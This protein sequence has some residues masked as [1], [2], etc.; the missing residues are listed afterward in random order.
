MKHPKA[1]ETLKKYKK[2]IAKK[3]GKSGLIGMFC[4]SS[5][6]IGFLNNWALV[7]AFFW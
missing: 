7:I 5:Y 2:T 1:F 3:A 4:Q 6:S